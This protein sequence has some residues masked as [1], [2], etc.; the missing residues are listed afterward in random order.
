MSAV[1]DTRA[2]LA[3]LLTEATGKVAFAYMPG[4]LNPPAWVIDAGSPYLD[5]GNTFGSLLARFDCVYF[6][7][8][9]AANALVT[10]E[11]DDV[12]EAAATG[13]FDSA[14]NVETVTVVDETANGAT[15]LGGVFTV[16]KK[17]NL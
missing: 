14:W 9:S 10:A 5:N 2:E 11:L 13:L 17:L 15:Y 12:F 1:A 16:T 4:S 3:A 7:K 6:T 8:P